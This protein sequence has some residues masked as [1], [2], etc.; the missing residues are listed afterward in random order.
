MGPGTSSSAFRHAVG[1]KFGGQPVVYSGNGVP[2]AVEDSAPRVDVVLPEEFL[3]AF[4]NGGPFQHHLRVGVEPTQERQ[5]VRCIIPQRSELVVVLQR[6]AGFLV[7]GA[8]PDRER[9]RLDV[10][11]Q[12][13]GDVRVLHETEP[14]AGR[15]LGPLLFLDVQQPE[16]VPG[17]AGIRPRGW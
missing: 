1:D 16:L 10:P 3:P 8:V 11:A 5:R 7:V 2:F 15:R 9:H 14:E 13:L 4:E 12:R 17:T 6:D